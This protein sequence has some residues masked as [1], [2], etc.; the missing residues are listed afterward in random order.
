[1]GKIHPSKPV[2]S[3][4]FGLPHFGQS[5]GVEWLC[6]RFLTVSRRF[7]SMPMIPL[8]SS[9]AGLCDFDVFFWVAHLV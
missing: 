1:M 6:F 2:D 7:L 9:R 3:L 8:C 4:I 5:L